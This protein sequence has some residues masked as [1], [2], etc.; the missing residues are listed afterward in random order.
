MPKLKSNRAASKRFRKTA[1]GFKSSVTSRAKP[2]ASF[3]LEAQASCM[4]VMSVV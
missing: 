2:S 3:A 1:K 4:R